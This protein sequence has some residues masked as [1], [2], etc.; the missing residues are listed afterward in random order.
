MLLPSMP[1][2]SPR[3][4]RRRD[5]HLGISVTARA[6]KTSASASQVP[7]TRIKSRTVRLSIPGSSTPG[8]RNTVSS[9]V[10]TRTFPRRVATLNVSPS[11]AATTPRMVCRRS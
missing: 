10:S 2:T 3:M 8:M 7:T 9:L 11:M 4:K 1:V 5:G 6:L